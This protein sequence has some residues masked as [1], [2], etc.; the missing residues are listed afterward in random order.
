MSRRTVPSGWLDAAV[1]DVLYAFRTFRR[2]PLPALVVVATVALGLGLVG[3]AFA[4]Y[5]TLFLRVDAVRAP[6]E[7]FAVERTASGTGE[8]QL[9]TWLDYDALRADTSHH[10]DPRPCCLRGLAPTARDSD[11]RSGRSARHADSSIDWSPPEFWRG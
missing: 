2:A 10:G 8:G 1:R 3:A 9:L 4:V 7:L 6:H 5:D 11:P